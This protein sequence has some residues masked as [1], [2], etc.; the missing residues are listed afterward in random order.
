[1]YKPMRETLV[2]PQHTQ[3]YVLGLNAGTAK[4]AGFI[5]REKNHAT[6][7]FCISFKHGSF[8]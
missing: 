4:L 8:V 3:Q 6:R 2:F 7:F 1:M 5:T